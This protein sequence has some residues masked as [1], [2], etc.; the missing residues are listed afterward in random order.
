MVV[1]LPLEACALQIGIKMWV[2][3][4]EIVM[5]IGGLGVEL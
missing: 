1:G 2:K 5:S 4:V 3:Y